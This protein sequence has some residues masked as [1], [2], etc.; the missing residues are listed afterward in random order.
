MAR[1]NGKSTMFIVDL[2]PG[3][4]NMANHKWQIV[5]SNVF[6]FSP[7]MFVFSESNAMENSHL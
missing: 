2:N 7:P 5:L 4:F 6:V 1:K 3:M